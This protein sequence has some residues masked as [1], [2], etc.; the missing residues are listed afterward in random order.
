MRTLPVLL[1]CCSA[2][3]LGSAPPPPSSSA[4]VAAIL[5]AEQEICA[6]F[7]REDADWLEAHLDRS[8]TLVNS[9][10]KV[11]T[12]ADEIADLRAGTRYDLFRNRDS[13]VRVYGD[14]AVVTGITRVEGRARGEGGES[15]ARYAIDFRFTDTY[16]RRSSGWVMVAS[17]ASRMDP[18]PQQGSLSETGE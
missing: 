13:K 17:H 1:A 16:A 6:A 12:A 7:E 2:I 18:Q 4:D 5:E 11:T 14:A 8:F 3:A 15:D 9:A 10:G